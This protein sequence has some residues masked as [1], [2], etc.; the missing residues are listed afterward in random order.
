MPSTDT[1]TPNYAISV[2]DDML[3]GAEEM[4]AFTGNTVRRMNYLLEKRCVPAYKEGR[5]WRMRKSTY[6]RFVEQREAAVM[7]RLICAGVPA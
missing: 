3:T 1:L 4:A 6:L 7:E 2:A 5:I